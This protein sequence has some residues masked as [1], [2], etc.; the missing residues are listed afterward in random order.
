M[1]HIAK[2]KTKNQKIY[3]HALSDNEHN[4][5][6]T[7]GFAGTG[8]TYLAANWAA[9]ALDKNKYEKIILIRAPEP[10]AGRTVGFLKGGANEKMEPWL[11]QINSYIKDAIGHESFEQYVL[12]E[13]I[14]PQLLETVRGMSF[15]NSIVIVDES[16]LLNKK[17][18]QALTTRIGEK[19]KIIF[20]GDTTQTENNSVGDDGLS[21]LIYLVKTYN[22]KCKLV[23]FDIH[24]CMRS[25][26][27]KQF[28][29]AFDS[30]S[31]SDVNNYSTQT[32]NKNKRSSRFYRG[33]NEKY[34]NI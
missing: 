19:S 34:Q 5:I 2:P 18:I 29:Q 10:L 30:D 24:D 31:W 12:E 15:N 9:H 7:R 20:C 27:C 6:I 21:Y 1:S 11:T 32:N 28:L 26:L 23:E 8:K 33:Y 13:R 17:E 4:L 16:Q 14:I 22:I 25:D 3:A